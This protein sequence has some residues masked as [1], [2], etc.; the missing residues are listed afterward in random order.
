MFIN[1]RLNIT[2]WPSILKATIL[3]TE[4]RNGLDLNRFQLHKFT[5]A[6]FE[7]M[8]FAEFTVHICR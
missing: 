8:S 7:T 6:E 4:N 1:G 5:P 3:V 2:L